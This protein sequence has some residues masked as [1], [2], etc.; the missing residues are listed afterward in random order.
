MQSRVHAISLQ[1]MAVSPQHY[2]A[3]P[4]RKLSK[5][6]RGWTK[7]KI[8]FLIREVFKRERKHRLFMQ[9]GS[10]VKNYN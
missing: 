6:Q 10:N 8:L 3:S 9:H 7:D 1:V 4:H 2:E 5:R